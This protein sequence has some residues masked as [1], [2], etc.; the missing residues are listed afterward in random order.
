MST[1]VSVRTKTGAIYW[2]EQDVSGKK[3]RISADRASTLVASA[4]KRLH[5]G[6]GGG[7][8]GEQK[9]NRTRTK[10]QISAPRLPVESG[11]KSATRIATKHILVFSVAGHAGSGKTHL[12]EKWDDPQVA[13]YD[14]DYVEDVAK[15]VQTTQDAGKKAV[16][17]C[18]LNESSKRPPVDRFADIPNVTK[19][20]RDVSLDD[21]IKRGL[22][23]RGAGID[24][25]NERKVAQ[26]IAW[27]KEQDRLESKHAIPKN[28][29]LADRYFLAQERAALLRARLDLNPSQLDELSEHEVNGLVGKLQQ[30]WSNGYVSSIDELI[31]G[32]G[33]D[34]KEKHLAMGYI[35]IPEGEVTAYIKAALAATG[36]TAR[37]TPRR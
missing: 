37:S 26:A 11:R 21:W 13:T 18:G 8:G 16:I 4:G 23:R 35:T 9:T 32:I 36:S 3:T 25:N 33:R 29:G 24:L 27:L 28:I 19:I 14:L 34:R 30:A 12:C 22:L 15:D 7:G 20:W 31:T 1:V 2:Y 17:F 5:V 10:S 6:G